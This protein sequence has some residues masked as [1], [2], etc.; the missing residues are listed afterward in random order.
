[1]VFQKWQIF[2]IKKYCQKK[3]ANFLENSDFWQ[4]LPNLAS[5]GNPE[6]LVL[7]AS[8]VFLCCVK[9]SASEYVAI[10]VHKEGKTGVCLFRNL[11]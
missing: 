6:W 7:A 8:H 1:L 5:S 10:G 9:T 2:G 4:Y 11:V 3:L